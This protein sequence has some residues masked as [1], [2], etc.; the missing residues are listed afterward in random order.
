MYKDFIL[1]ALTHLNNENEAH[2]DN[3]NYESIMRKM[4][5]EIGRVY[6]GKP[7]YLPILGDGI[8]RFDGVSEKPSPFE[9]LKCMLCTL[10]TSNVQLKAPITIVV[11]DRINEISLYNLKKFIA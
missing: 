8:T 5:Q 1:L 7:I 9:L 3:L 11:Y 6:S 10:K 2:I 4:W